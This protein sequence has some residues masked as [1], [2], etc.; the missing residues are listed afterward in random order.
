[1]ADG[2]NVRSDG[3]DWVCSDTRSDDGVHP[4]VPQ[5]AD[6]IAG[7]LLTFFQNDATANVWFTEEDDFLLLIIP[8]IISEAKN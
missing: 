3:F 1:M 7:E 4:S 2:V 6:K 8:P 5:G